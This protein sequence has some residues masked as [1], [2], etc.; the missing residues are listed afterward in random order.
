MFTNFI[1]ATLDESLYDLAGELVLLRAW[2]FFSKWYSNLTWGSTFI[3][4]CFVI[5]CASC[6]G[7]ERNMTR[8]WLIQIDHLPDFW[9]IFFSVPV[10]RSHHWTRSWYFHP[11]LLYIFETLVIVNFWK[12]LTNQV[13]FLWSSNSLKEQSAHIASVKSILESHASYLMS[14]KELSKLVAFVKGTQFDLMVS[15]TYSFFERWSAPC[16]VF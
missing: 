12:L 13:P 15:K 6:W 1:Q 16:T 10:T 3:S 2:L 9:V 8:H 4:F 11:V 14:G 5:R 7:L